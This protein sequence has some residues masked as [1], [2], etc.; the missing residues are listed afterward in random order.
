MRR[1]WLRRNRLFQ[2]NP[3]ELGCLGGFFGFA[4]FFGGVQERRPWAFKRDDRPKGV[5]FLIISTGNNLR[6]SGAEIVTRYTTV[7][8]DRRIF[9]DRDDL[10]QWIKDNKLG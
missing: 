8:I 10:D 5:S 7:P 6:I 9:V 1:G 2:K 3:P 4:H